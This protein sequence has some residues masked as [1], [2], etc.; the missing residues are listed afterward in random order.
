MVW[1]MKVGIIIQARMGSSRLPGKVM[2]KIQDKTILNHIILR[3]RQ[4]KE[5]QEI[6]VATST[7]QQ[8][9]IIEL[10]TN[11]LDVKCF[12]GEE[13][14]VLSRYY[15]AAREN[16]LDIIVRITADCPLIDPYVID[17]IIRVFKA[18]N[19]N[20]VTNAV[21]DI[22]ERTFPRGLDTEVFSKESLNEAFFNAR[23]SYQREHVT[24]YIYKC[25]KNTHI[26]KN[27]I[28]YSNHRWT[29]D[30]TEDLAL[31]KEIY[32]SLYKEKHNFYLK[33]IIEFISKNPSLKNI[34]EHIEQKKLI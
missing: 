9:D 17:E 12:R 32:A 4:C 24:P 19:Y 30:T 29:L 14:D 8:D 23:E 28:N 16:Q 7:L 2:I 1:I 26:F 31:I 10:E 18:S 20:I 3:T 25:F 5:V 33:D 21:A 34:N 22:T 6:I 27:S 13:N 11:K 15:H